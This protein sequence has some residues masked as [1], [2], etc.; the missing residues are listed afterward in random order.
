MCKDAPSWR[1]GELSLINQSLRTVKVVEEFSHVLELGTVLHFSMLIMFYPH[2]GNNLI[3]A[4]ASNI[5]YATEKLDP[6]QAF[7]FRICFSIRSRRIRHVL[8]S[9][10]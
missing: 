3:S 5:C 4:S 10:V 1:L 7:S 9:K 6:N 2:F 8:S